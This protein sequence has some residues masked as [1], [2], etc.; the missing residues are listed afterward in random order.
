MKI[1]VF[2]ILVPCSLVEVT[3]IPE[4][5]ARWVFMT[6]AASASE[7]SVKFYWTTWRKNPEDSHL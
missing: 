6:E 1:A 3:D 5:T 2:W 7:T 4:V